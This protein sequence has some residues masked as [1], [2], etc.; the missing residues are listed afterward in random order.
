M[1]SGFETQGLNIPKTNSKFAR[2]KW[3]VSPD[4]QDF[5]AYVPGAGFCGEFQVGEI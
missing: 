1:N 3:M 2:K 5:Q 4:F